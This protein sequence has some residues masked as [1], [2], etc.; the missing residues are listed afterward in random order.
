L[1]I[2]ALEKN[3]RATPCEERSLL[4]KALNITQG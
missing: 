4:T 3:K 2:K 1:S